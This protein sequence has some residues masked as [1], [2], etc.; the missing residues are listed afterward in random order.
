MKNT[1]ALVG[2][3]VRKFWEMNRRED[4]VLV[5]F[6][7]KYSFET[8]WDHITAVASPYYGCHEDSTTPTVV[9]NFDFC[10]GET[11]FRNFMCVYLDDAAQAIRDMLDAGRGYIGR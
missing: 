1:Y 7:Q 10:E 2:E 5:S 6:E 9:F 3:F 8:Q 4:D 11:D